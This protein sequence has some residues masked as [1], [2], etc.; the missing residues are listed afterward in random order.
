[1]CCMREALAVMTAMMKHNDLSVSPCMASD[2]AN[3]ALFLVNDE[4][5]P[6]TGQIMACDFGSTL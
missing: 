5:R 2:V 1:M 6:I 3:V 4:A